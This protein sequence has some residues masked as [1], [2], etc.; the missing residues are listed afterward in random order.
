[1]RKSESSVSFFDINKDVNSN[2]ESI[3]N[4]QFNTSKN[5]SKLAL[6]NNIDKSMQETVTLATTPP[7]SDVI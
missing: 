2:T 3:V 4:I 5:A 7:N 1:M 6:T